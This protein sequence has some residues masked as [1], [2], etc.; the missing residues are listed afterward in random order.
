MK[1]ANA[2]VGEGEVVAEIYASIF[3]DVSDINFVH[4]H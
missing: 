4:F 3:L 2:D 1:Q